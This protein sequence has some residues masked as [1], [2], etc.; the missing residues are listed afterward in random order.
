MKFSPS[1]QQTPLKDTPE[2]RAGTGST[3]KLPIHRTKVRRMMF[4]PEGDKLIFLPKEK[5][6]LVKVKKE[7]DAVNCASTSFDNDDF[8]IKIEPVDDFETE[9]NK[10]WA[11]NIEQFSEQG[12]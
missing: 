11:V 7:P 5:D 8:E 12:S 2:K 9:D 10:N 3:I 6:K 4:R 1:F